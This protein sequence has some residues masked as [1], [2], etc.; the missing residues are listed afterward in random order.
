MKK[1]FSIIWFSIVLSMVFLPIILSLINSF[2]STSDLLRGFFVIPE[3]ITFNNY[4]YI[5]IE[6]GIYRNIINSLFVTT[7]GVTLSLIINPFLS[8][9]IS[10]NWNKRFYRILYVFLSSCMFIPVNI[11]IIPLIKIYYSL[12]LMNTV[13]L[14]IF[15]AASYIPETVFML[16]PFFRT[17]GSEIGEAARLDGCT[18]LQFYLKVFLPI[19]SPYITAIAILNTVWIWNDFFIPMMILNRNP[20]NWTIPIFIYNYLGRN[21]FK[22]NYAFAACQIGILPI[23]VFYCTNHRRILEGLNL[24]NK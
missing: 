12:H 19:V 5:I 7:A 2:R 6:K 4:E 22:K 13:G 17:F 24:K 21:S 15:Y 9:M 23:T 18:E 14:L 10:E 1:T 8:F 11:L 16:V 3:T 20:N